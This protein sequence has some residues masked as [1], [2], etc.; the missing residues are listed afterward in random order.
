MKIAVY[1]A[2]GVGGYFGGRLARAGADVHLVARGEHLDAIRRD[3]LRVESVRGDFEV[4]LPATDDPASI[5]PC[6]VVLV[7]VKSYD[8]DEVAAELEPLLREETAVVSLQNGLDN[9]ER[10]SATI[11]SD[12][13][14]GGV[15]YVFSTI[16][17]PG[18][19]EHTGGPATFTFGELDG[20]R[21]ERGERLLEWCERADGMD[22]TLSGSIRTV[23]WEKAAFI[24]AQA[25]MTAAVRL[26]LG[27]IRDT[28][29]SWEMYRRIV[30]EVCRVGRATGVD[31][32]QGT[33][34]RW[35]EF[36]DDLDDDSYSSL[37]YDVTHDKPVEL[38][39]L[40]G[41]VVRRGREN[42]VAVPA[43]EA[44]YAIL[45]PWAVRNRRDR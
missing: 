40:H 31:L 6:D 20:T 11:G 25:G 4:D 9:E 27:R 39:A 36:A 44:V 2:G 32:P 34:D 12:R 13:V 28:E 8:T 17:E 30:E 26:P 43:N 10:L 23:L 16:H 15:A 7:T 24:C 1:G 14:V 33:V 18:V 35:M 45:R 42:D 21:S 22:A 38:E 37:H 3:G 5:G 41:A 29:E 19:I